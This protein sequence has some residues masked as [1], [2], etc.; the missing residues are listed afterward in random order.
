MERGVHMK[1]YKLVGKFRW[2]RVSRPALLLIRGGLALSC[3]LLA[4]SLLTAVY[5]GEITARNIRLF[6]LYVSLYKAPLGVLFLTT[7]G[8]LC[9]DAA[10]KG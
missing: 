8:A 6:F 5:A 3:V 10:F 7:L 9:I 4:L 2:D 1:L